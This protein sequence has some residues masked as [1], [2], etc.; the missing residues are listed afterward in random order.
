MVLLLLITFF[1]E[2]PMSIKKKLFVLVFVF[3]ANLFGQNKTELAFYNIGL[4]A[5]GS[6]I[7][8]VIN[9]K[10]NEKW[11]KVFFKGFR[12]GAL[13]GY[14]IHESKNLL[15]LI[16]ERRKLEYSWGAKILNAAGV[17][18]VENAALNKN[19]WKKWHF[20]IGFNRFELEL[21][22]KL[23]FRY[24]IKP[25]AFVSVI[26]TA[27]NN[28][29][30]FEE[31][32]RT[33]EFIFTNDK[34]SLFGTP[35]TGK[36]IGKSVVIDKSLLDTE[37]EIIAHEILHTYQYEDYNFVNSFFESDLKIAET[38]YPRFDRL[39]D[40]F[41]LDFHGA[42]FFGLYGLEEI[43]KNSSSDNFFEN[44]ADQYSKTRIR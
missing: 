9:K 8:S 11:G 30:E 6:S 7:G 3:S 2:I 42:L 27:S 14:L 18:I 16:G 5:L 38:K 17:S 34:V 43:G 37:Y 40:L 24:K 32:F 44:E 41:Y 19:F 28:K 20:D 25:M 13:G 26:I 31:S 1:K 15:G 35:V 21:E 29:F 39:R 36:A 10:P 33:G 23:K 12:Q 4:G 22:N